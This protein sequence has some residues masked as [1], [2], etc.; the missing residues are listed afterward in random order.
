MRRLARDRFVLEMSKEHPPAYSIEEGERVIVEC[1]DCHGGFVNRDGTVRPGSPGPNPATG[2][3]EVKDAQPGEALAITIHDVKPADWGFIAGGGGGE[4]F[5]VIEISPAGR[6]EGRDGTATYPWGL[7][8]PVNPVIGVIG[9]APS[10][11]P[12]PNTTPGD[13]GGNL[14]TPDICPGA[15]V[16][17]PVAIPGAMLALGDVHALQGDSECSGTGI[18]CAAEV[19]LSVKRMKQALWP[20]PLILRDD[21]LMLL[22]SA[23][24]LDE[25]AW[26]AVAEMAK[27][28]TQ[29][30]GL[31]DVEARRLLS[32]VGDIRIS[33]IVNPRKTCRAIIPKSAIPGRWPF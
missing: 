2:P 6:V 18:E 1:H 12:V 5:T 30:T 15:T 28:L 10:G 31:S 16:L 20:C 9:L 21:K 23:D 32:T 22:A 11:D 7:R 17:L 29:L 8:L 19:T 13:H 25:A 33:Q 14:D 24:T 3:I 26:K 27:L 4:P